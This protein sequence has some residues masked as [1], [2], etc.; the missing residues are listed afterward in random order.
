MRYV[1]GSRSHATPS[2][3]STSIG[4]AWQAGWRP[5]RGGLRVLW[6][7]CGCGGSL[8]TRD[9]DA[10]SYTCLPCRREAQVFAANLRAKDGAPRRSEGDD[11]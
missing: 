2:A 5:G 9:H 7:V 4:N 1:K 6:C 8:S 3:F 11:G 10:H